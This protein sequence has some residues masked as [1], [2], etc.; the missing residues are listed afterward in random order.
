MNSR[1]VTDLAEA[2]ALAPRLRVLQE[3]A[4]CPVTARWTWQRTWLR[5]WDWERLLLVIVERGPELVAAAPLAARRRGRTW[6]VVPVGDGPSDRIQF[7]ACEAGDL[8]HAVSEALDG[9]G[10]WRLR[11]RHLDPADPVGVALHAALPHSGTVPGDLSPTTRF[12]RTRDVRTYVSRNAHQQVRRMHNRVAREG[13]ALELEVL[14]SSAELCQVLP[15]L[16]RVH[17][18][19]DLQLGRASAVDDPALG[20]FLRLLLHALAEDGEVELTVVRLDGELAAYVLCLVDSDSRRMWNCRFDPE[21]ERYAPGRLALYAALETALADPAC[22]EFDWMRGTE[23]YK[24]QL[25]NAAWRAVDLHACSSPLAWR[26]RRTLLSTACRLR[27]V[28]DRH[29]ALANA[30]E[31]VRRWVGRCR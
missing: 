11:I 5:C 20:P 28:R 9:L 24:T 29:P 31:H 19:R 12:G 26:V 7:A 15:Q 2:E 25:S 30:W 23:P 21:W 16:E 6:H 1:L 27:A 10:R 8:A 14:R 3:R 18:A 17:R 22:C 4:G 13:H